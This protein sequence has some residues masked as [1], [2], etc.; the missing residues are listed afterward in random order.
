LRSALILSA[1]ATDENSGWQVAGDQLAESPGAMSGLQV[2]HALP[3]LSAAFVRADPQ[4]QDGTACDSLAVLGGSRLR[5][6]DEPPSDHR[7]SCRFDHVVVATG[8]A[9]SWAGD[10]A[11]G[12]PGDGTGRHAMDRYLGVR[13][14]NSAIAQRG[15]G[16]AEPEADRR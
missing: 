11:G 6:P 2:L 16:D 15:S 5:V 8:S 10:H 4:A 14:V 13:P 3:L 9:P 1:A 7:G 12:H